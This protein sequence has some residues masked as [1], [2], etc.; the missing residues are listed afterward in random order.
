MTEEEY[1][2]CMAKLLEKYKGEKYASFLKN[3]NRTY[4]NMICR[5]FC[6]DKLPNNIIDCREKFS[7]LYVS[8]F[9]RG[10]VYIDNSKFSFTTVEEFF[11]HFNIKNE[12]MSNASETPT[13][14]IENNVRVQYNKTK[15]SLEELLKIYKNEEYNAVT[16]TDIAFFRGKLA[17]YESLLKVN[18]KT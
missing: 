10:V 2:Y 6:Y 8:K 15:K 13:V 18:S 3:I 12:P 17:A 4:N 1:K 7:L 9:V 16:S 5:E 11:K 14:S